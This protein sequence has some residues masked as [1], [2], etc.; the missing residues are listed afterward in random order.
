VKTKKEVTY[1]SSD[2][3]PGLSLGTPVLQ[4]SKSS[5]TS[6]SFTFTAGVTSRQIWSGSKFD[7]VLGWLGDNIW[8]E[9]LVTFNALLDQ[10]KA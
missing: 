9:L 10:A 2:D 8:Q 1:S 4:T 6:F 5:K 7:F 3:T